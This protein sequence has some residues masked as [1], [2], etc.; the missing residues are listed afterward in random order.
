MY[1]MDWTNKNANPEKLVSIG[2]EITNIL[3]T[4][5]LKEGE[6]RSVLSNANQIRGQNS[7]K[8]I[9]LVTLLQERL[10]PLLILEFLL[11]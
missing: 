5:I 10:N 11:D 1:Q 6:S 9:M 2:Q 8:I 3:D 7:L 4:S